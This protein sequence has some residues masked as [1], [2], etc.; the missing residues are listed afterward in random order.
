M[1]VQVVKDVWGVEIWPVDV[2]LV[3]IVVSKTFP[4]RNMLGKIVDEEPETDIEKHPC[5][6]NAKWNWGRN[7]PIFTAKEVSKYF[8]DLLSDERVGTNGIMKISVA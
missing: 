4:R 2:K 7:K 1:E 8:P 6:T 5:W 3:Y